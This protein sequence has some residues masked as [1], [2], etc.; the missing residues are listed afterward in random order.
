MRVFRPRLE[1]VGA[2]LFTTFVKGA[3]G[4]RRDRRVRK[5]KSPPGG[6]LL[7]LKLFDRPSCSCKPELLR[8]NFSFAA[9][10]EKFE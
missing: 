10:D 4:G 9:A 5:T 8:T 2:A 3:R 1:F 6:G 7:R